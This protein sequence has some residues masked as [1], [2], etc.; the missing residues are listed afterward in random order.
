MDDEILNA[1]R[2]W[3]CTSAWKVAWDMAANFHRERDLAA[4]SVG[5][6]AQFRLTHDSNAETCRQTVI[7]ESGR[8]LTVKNWLRQ[9]APRLLP[10]VPVVDFFDQQPA[11]FQPFVEAMV[12]LESELLSLPST[13]SQATRD[14]TA[15]TETVNE[16]MFS[17][18]GTRPE[19][20]GWSA[21][22]WADHLNVKSK[23]TIAETDA[24]QSLKVVKA[25]AAI[26]AGAKPKD[27]HRKR[28]ASDLNRSK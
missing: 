16:R 3:Q 22:Q 15:S 27:R 5:E 10:L 7:A 12:K 1:V 18:L 25:D 13:G 26:K 21:Q 24:W 17:T 23:S 9:N 19:S 2:W 20:A 11:D 14:A 8:L 6:L 28:K 4:T